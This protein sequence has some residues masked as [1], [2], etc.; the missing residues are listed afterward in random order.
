MVSEIVPFSSHFTYFRIA[1]SKTEVQYHLLCTLN[2]L[3]IVALGTYHTR[4]LKSTKPLKPFRKQSLFQQRKMYLA[5]Q[6]KY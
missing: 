3:V 5:S 1:I 2:G 4:R 6:G